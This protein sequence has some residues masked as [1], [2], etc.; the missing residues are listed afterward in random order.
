MGFNSGSKGLNGTCIQ[1]KPIFRGK[2]YSLG[3]LVCRWSI[4]QELVSKG[5]FYRK[6][7]ISRTRWFCY[8]PFPSVTL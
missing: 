6:K 3:D 8:R 1:L 5:D 2:L 4:F 7:T